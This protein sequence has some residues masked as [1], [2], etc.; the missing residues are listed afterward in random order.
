[1]RDYGNAALNTTVKGA[2]FRQY[3][4]RYVQN[5]NF[6]F[7]HYCYTMAKVKSLIVGLKFND[8]RQTIRIP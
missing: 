1:M 6:S 5:V 3:G 2:M 4:V 7:T 8:Y